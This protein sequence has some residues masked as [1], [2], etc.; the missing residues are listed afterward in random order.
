MDFEFRTSF[1]SALIRRRTDVLLVLL[2]SRFKKYFVFF[3]SCL[4]QFAFDLIILPWIM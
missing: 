3:S 4:Y 2:V 1:S